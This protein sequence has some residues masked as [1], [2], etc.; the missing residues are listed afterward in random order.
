MPRYEILGGQRCGHP[1][2]GGPCK[3]VVMR[4]VPER[5]DLLSLIDALLANAEALAD[6]AGLLYEHERYPRA[7]ALGALAGEELGKVY[8]CLEALLSVEGVDVQQF[9]WGWRH[10][11]DKLDSMR[12][13]AAAFIEDLDEFDV[14]RLAT[15]AK[16]IG[17]QKLSALYVDFD[18]AQVLVP[19]RVTQRDAADLL[20]RCRLSIGHLSGALAGLNA[21]IVQV[22]HVLGPALEAFFRRVIDDRSPQEVLAELRQIVHSLPNMTVDE[23]SLLLTSRIE[24]TGP[25]ATDM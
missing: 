16:Q 3:P 4:L 8:L 7:Y 15:D 24:G 11:G 22:T 20:H 14:G 25:S 2:V 1:N 13:Y 10:H 5:D 23:I 18:G 12:A 6:D 19:D 17:A 9:W 21:Q